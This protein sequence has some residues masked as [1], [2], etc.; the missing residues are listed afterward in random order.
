MACCPPSCFSE[1][2]EMCWEGKCVVCV[3]CLISITAA[4]HESLYSSHHFTHLATLLISPLCF[5][6]NKICIKSR[7][8]YGGWSGKVLCQLSILSMTHPDPQFYS[9]FL[10]SVCLL[11]F[12]FYRSEGDDQHLKIKCIRY[13]LSLNIY[14]DYL[15]VCTLIYLFSFTPFI[16]LPSFIYLFPL[17][18]CNFNS[19]WNLKTKVVY[20]RYIS[21]TLSILVLTT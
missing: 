12:C 3:K 8:G 15:F 19:H 10:M 11:L 16:F 13:L 18:I 4:F 1:W 2:V 7:R 14:G 5:Q 17:L 21:T 20:W 9:L 6:R